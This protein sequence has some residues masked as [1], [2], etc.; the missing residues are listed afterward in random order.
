MDTEFF[1]ALPPDGLVRQL[2]RPYM[3]AD[4]VPAVG[5][6]PAR[7]M[8]M[9]QEHETVAH[10]CSY[11]DRSLGDHGRTLGT[12]RAQQHAGDAYPARLGS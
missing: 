8:A 1:E 12:N 11:C 2:A 5:V 7:W 6:P 3:S 10:K 9:H 4:E